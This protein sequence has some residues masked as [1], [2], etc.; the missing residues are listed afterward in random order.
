MVNPNYNLGVVVV[1]KIILFQMQ[2]INLAN[3]NNLFLLP[4]K[5][6]QKNLLIQYYFVEHNVDF[7]NL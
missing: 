6:L 2:L 7:Y 3:F 1:R 4:S 5:C